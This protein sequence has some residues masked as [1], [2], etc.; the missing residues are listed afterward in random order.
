[1][2][3]DIGGTISAALAAVTSR[4]GGFIGLWAIYLG[5]TIVATI[6]FALMAGAGGLASASLIGPD[7]VNTGGLGAL[8]AGFIVA[9]ILFYV[10]YIYLSMAQASSMIALASPLTQ[11][12]FGEALSLG[13]RAGLPLLGAGLLMLVGYFVIMVPLSML[14]SAMG[15]AGS[16]VSLGMLVLL[17]F[18]ACRLS[19]LPAVAAVEQVTNPI[20][21]ITRTWEITSGSVLRI[22]VVL[23][24]F[25]V[26]VLALVILLALPVYGSISQGTAPGG[27]TIAYMIVAFIAAFFLIVVFQ[28][29]IIA[30]IHAQLSGRNGQ[31]MEETFG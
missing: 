11:A 12:T 27:G 6:V 4:I 26:F 5:L 3:L 30:A 21:I 15:S 29:S 14:A 31:N 19:V 16:I 25:V 13:F 24:I 22:L 28:H 7:G 1:M 17:V 23:V 10:A 9:M 20:A 18:L 8:G 2:K